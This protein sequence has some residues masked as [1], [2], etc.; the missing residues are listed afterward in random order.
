MPPNTNSTDG[1]LEIVRQRLLTFVPN[2]RIV[3][4][5]MRTLAERIGTY[6]NGVTTVPRLWLENV[7][8]DVSE[9]QST[10]VTLWGLLQII[11]TRQGG[12]DGGFFRRGEIEVQLFGRPRRAASEL[13]GMADV[14]EQALHGWINREGEGGYIR[15]FGGLTR[16][17]IKYDQPADKELG[18][19]QLRVM[20]SYA[21]TF[22][23]Q[24]SS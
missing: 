7:P 5:D 20:M 16:T 9:D 11:P 18:Q 10:R 14:V 6:T 13:S 19:I 12:D 1:M 21:P 4:G 24:S 17:K 2:T 3:G 22:L 15:P 23:T 8:N